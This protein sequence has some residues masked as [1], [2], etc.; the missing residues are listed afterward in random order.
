[1]LALLPLGEIDQQW[2]KIVTQQPRLIGVDKF[3]QYFESTYLNQNCTF[4]RQVWNH[5]DTVGPRTNNHV[6]GYHLK[7]KLVL[8]GTAHQDVM[9]V[10]KFLKEDWNNA[11]LVWFR[12]FP[13][14]SDPPPPRNKHNIWKDMG[15]HDRK[16]ML[17]EGRIDLETYIMFN[18]SNFALDIDEPK[19]KLPSV[20]GELSD[21]ELLDDDDSTDSSDSDDDNDTNQF[22]L[23]Q[24]QGAITRSTQAQLTQLTS[25]QPAPTQPLPTQTQSRTQT[26]AASVKDQACEWC[27]K[28]YTAGGINKHRFSCPKKPVAN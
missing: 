6:E 9:A 20:N 21:E 15:F 1:M 23:L 2:T 28:C 18:I 5:F 24:V 7:L 26:K 16:R 12:S 17:V 13:P 14:S 19:K 3:V 10:L 11:E 22:P 25:T 8:G 27:G 4:P